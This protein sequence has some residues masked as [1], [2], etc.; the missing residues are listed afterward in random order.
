MPKFTSGIVSS[1]LLDGLYVTFGQSALFLG[2]CI[3]VRWDGL[4]GHDHVIVQGYLP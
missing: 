3:V 1:E 4:E 2:L